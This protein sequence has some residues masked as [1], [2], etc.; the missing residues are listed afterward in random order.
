MGNLVQF[1]TVTV[2]PLSCRMNDRLAPV[3]CLD[4][5]L[6]RLQNDTSA[7]CDKLHG[8]LARE[9]ADGLTDRDGSTR[10]TGLT[11]GHD[12]GTTNVGCENTEGSDR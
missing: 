3:R 1:R 7:L 6:R 5:K 11:K 10:A 2:K 9:K 8:N 12:G 4:P